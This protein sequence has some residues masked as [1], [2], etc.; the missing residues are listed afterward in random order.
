MQGAHEKTSVGIRRPY[1]RVVGIQVET[2]GHSRVGVGESLSPE[3]EEVMQQLAGQQD[4]YNIFSRSIAPSIYGST[5]NWL[6]CIDAQLVVTII[7]ISNE[8]LLACCLVDLV[9]V[10]LMD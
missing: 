9:N 10:S 4:I 1:L 6:L 7:Q 2:E 5:G 8:L 3:E